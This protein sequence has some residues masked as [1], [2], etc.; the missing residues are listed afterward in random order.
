MK[1]KILELI[2]SF[3]LLAKFLRMLR[4]NTFL[5]VQYKRF[6]TGKG[7]KLR[8]DES[9]LFLKC[10]FDIIGN[11]NEI[12][13]EEST[14]FNNVTFNIRGNNNMIW[15]SKRVAF[16]K[17]GLLY[18]EDEN[19]EIKIGERTTFEDVHLAVTEPKSKITIGEDC[20]FAYDIDLR[21]GDSHSIL[22]STTM[23]RTNYARNVEIDDHVW[24]A[25]HVSILKGVKLLKNTVVATRSVVTKSFEKEGILIGGTPVKVL[26]EGITWDRKRIY[27]NSV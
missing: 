17:G 22:D 10:K 3:P 8:I 4:R 21:T 25:S 12:I 13:I 14:L 1:S 2:K 18:I 27:E 11:N 15:I 26:K 24:V 23:K 19:C 16:N 20:M 7:N 6:I 9:A 5:K